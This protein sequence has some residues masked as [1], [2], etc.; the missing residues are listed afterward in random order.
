MHISTLIQFKMPKENG[1][2]KKVHINYFLKSYFFNFLR[3]TVYTKNFLL[4][5]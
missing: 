3:F 5:I 1:F 4:F 2:V